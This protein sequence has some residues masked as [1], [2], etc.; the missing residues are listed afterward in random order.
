[1]ESIELPDSYGETCLFLMAVEPSL[2][3]VIWDVD[4]AVLKGIKDQGRD[5]SHPVRF[6]LR[7]HDVT[8]IIFHGEKSLASFDVDI[9]LNE[10]KRYVPL[11]NAG[12]A[13]WAEIGTINAAGSFSHI[14]RSNVT[15]TPRVGTIPETERQFVMVQEVAAQEG[16]VIDVPPEPLSHERSS[17]EKGNGP[18]PCWTMSDEQ[19]KTQPEETGSTFSIFARDVL[20]GSSLFHKPRLGAEQVFRPGISAIRVIQEREQKLAGAVDLTERCEKTFV[21]GISSK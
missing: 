8:S 5:D 6:I 11:R 4:P 10:K 7:F 17:P 2:V 12:R 3:H 9:D 1:L 13:Y 14:V 19:E 16:A 18:L 20:K 15:E 21:A